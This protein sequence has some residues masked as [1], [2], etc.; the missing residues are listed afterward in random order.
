MG[1]C[2]VKGAGRGARVALPPQEGTVYKVLFLGRTHGDQML[3]GWGFSSRQASGVVTARLWKGRGKQTSR[4]ERS[5]SMA[6]MALVGSGGLWRWFGSKQGYHWQHI[7]QY[8]CL[9]CL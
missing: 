9:L 6:G 1:L 5:P 4:S 3:E 2:G 7:S 8:I